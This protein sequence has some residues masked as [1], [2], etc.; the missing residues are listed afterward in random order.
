M[1]IFSVYL[2]ISSLFLVVL[3]YVFYNKRNI[4]N[5]EAEWK[6]QGF[7]DFIDPNVWIPIGIFVSALFWPIVIFNCIKLIRLK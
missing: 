7:P 2:L 3:C 4:P 5:V 1:S 6:K